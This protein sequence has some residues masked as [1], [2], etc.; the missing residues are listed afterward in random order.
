MAKR[1]MEAVFST[2]SWD[3]PLT[4]KEL[5]DFRGLMGK[6]TIASVVHEGGSEKL[7]N[8]FIPGFRPR[9]LQLSRFRQDF[10]RDYGNWQFGQDNWD[11]YHVFRVSGEISNFDNPSGRLEV[12]TEGGPITFRDIACVAMAETALR[13]GAYVPEG[14]RSL[15][16]ILDP[17]G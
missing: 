13:V 5:E 2:E 15:D 16:H 11:P 4:G 14:A 3:R 8:R 9:S 6:W 17:T 10:C 7:F 1:R 12:A